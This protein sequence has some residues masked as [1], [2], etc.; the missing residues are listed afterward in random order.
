MTQLRGL[1]NTH[2]ER[3]TEQGLEL[4]EQAVKTS[5]EETIPEG[6]RMVSTL[7]SSKSWR[8]MS[9]ICDCQESHIKKI[10]T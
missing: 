6:C 5:L 2:H 8:Q 10:I 3:L 1:E 7:F 9:N 4:L